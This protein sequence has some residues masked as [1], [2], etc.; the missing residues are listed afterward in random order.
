VLPDG[1]WGDDVVDGNV[2][3]TADSSLSAVRVRI[4]KVLDEVGWPGATETDT[5]RAINSGNVGLVR[6]TYAPRTSALTVI[7]EA[8]E[9]D[10]PVVSG[11]FHFSRAGVARFFGRY[12]RIYPAITEYG[13]ETWELGD[14]AAADAAPA[15]VIPIA[16][17][18]VFQVDDTNL[19]NVATCT[20]Q[21]IADADIVDQVV[22]DATSIGA[23]GVL[24]WSAENL[25]TANGEGPTT[26]AEECLKF[27]DFVV[28]NYKDPMIRVGTLNVTRRMPGQPFA[29]KTW[30][31]LCGVELNDIVELTHT[32]GW[33]GGFLS[34]QF[35]VERIR[36]EI[37]PMNGQ[38]DDVRLLLDVS[39]GEYAAYNPFV[40]IS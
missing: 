27:A 26:A 39:P 16:P 29:T 4:V 37:E 23:Y 38:I 25:R 19:F 11:G 2:V 28:G 31:L 15:D 21:G 5:L 12:T 7:Q 3:Y 14:D 22:S 17:P 20:Y 36:Y 10:F 34:D 8:C 35:F 9:A 24:Q 6:T 32:M 33:A 13:I 40:G 18:L 30:A 1:L